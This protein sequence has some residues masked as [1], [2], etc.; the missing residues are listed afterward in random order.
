MTDAERQRRRYARKKAGL[1]RIEEWVPAAAVADVK[2]AIAQV[3]EGYRPQDWP[4]ME[5]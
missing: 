3:L 2:A 1:V 5:E 4:K